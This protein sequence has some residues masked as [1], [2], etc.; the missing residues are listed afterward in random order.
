[1]KRFVALCK[2][3]PVRHQNVHE[4]EAVYPG[5]ARQQYGRKRTY[6][7][8]MCTGERAETAS[9]FAIVD[10]L[11]AVLAGGHLMPRACIALG[12]TPGVRIPR[13]AMGAACKP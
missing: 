8:G 7:F 4:I 2:S 13:G 1:M 10:D 11:G 5:Y 9:H 12:I 6:F 3:P